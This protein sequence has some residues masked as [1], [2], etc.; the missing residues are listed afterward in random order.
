MFIGHFGVAFAAKPISPRISLGALFAACQVADLLWPVFCLAGIERFS[1]DPGNTAFTPLNFEYY[2]YSHSL[3]MLAAWGVLF[4]AAYASLRRVRGSALVIAVLVLSHW[5]L[6]VATHRAD[7]PLAP[8]LHTWV[9]LGLWNS[10]PAT[11]VIES[12]IFIVGAWLYVRATRPRD[13]AGSIAL[14]ALVGVLALISIANAMSPPPP[15][16]TAVSTTALAMWLFVALAYYVDR[17]REP[18]GR[19]R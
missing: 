9:G 1:I 2:P 7:M 10:V 14:W 15:S 13:R 12:A 19:I 5:F 3:V 11:I 6:D 16:V 17:H 18:I 8:G 4:G